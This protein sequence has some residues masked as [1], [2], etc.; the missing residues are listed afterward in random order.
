MTRRLALAL[1]LLFAACTP[2]ARRLEETLPAT[3]GAWR[4]ESV[5]PLT[6]YPPAVGKQGVAAAAS[7]IYSGPARVEVHLYRMRSPTSA[8]E[9]LQ[10]WR[11][12][13]GL[14]VLSGPYFIVA[15]PGADGPSARALLEAL[16]KALK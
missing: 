6:S 9:L 16:G 1:P 13:E 5:Q 3:L 7:A 12:S 11:Q 15:R 8:F 2:A 14:A 10:T 4:R